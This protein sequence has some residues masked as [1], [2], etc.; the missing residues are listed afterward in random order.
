MLGWL[1]LPG[2]NGLK[3]TESNTLPPIGAGQPFPVTRD[4]KLRGGFAMDPGHEFDEVNDQLFGNKKGTPGGPINAGFVASYAALNGGKNAANAGQVMD[5][6]EPARLPILTG[7][8]REFAVCDA[9]YSSV[10]GPTWPNRFFVH[11][12]T[13]GGHVDNKLHR[14]AMPTIYD[15]LSQSGVS[16]RIYYH[17]IPQCLALTRLQGSFFK[18]KFKKFSRFLADARQAALPAYSFIEPRY[19]TWFKRYPANDQHPPHDVEHGEALIADV[20][21]ALRGSPAWPHTLLIITYDEHGGI[22]DH[23]HPIEG[24]PPG[25]A[26]GDRFCR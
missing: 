25:D 16:W 10:P 26:A 23:E 21:D 20:Y 4:A 6:F 19:F 2:M 15:R 13:S 3:G 7:L 14:Y 9:W 12:A 5:C 22:Y 18:G 8:A 17:D 24:K 11:A 1:D